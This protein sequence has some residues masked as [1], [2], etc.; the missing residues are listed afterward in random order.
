MQKKTEFFALVNSKKSLKNNIDP[1]KDRNNIL[2]YK[3]IDIANTINK[4]FA[5]VF[6]KEDLSFNQTPETVFRRCNA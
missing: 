6:T 1:I 5:S 3:D 2:H 4:Y